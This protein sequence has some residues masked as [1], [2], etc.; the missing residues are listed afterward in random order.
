MSGTRWCSPDSEGEARCTSSPVWGEHHLLRAAAASCSPSGP[1]SAID[2]DNTWKS[3]EVSLLSVGEAVLV[4]QR[5]ARRRRKVRVCR[6]REREG[7]ALRKGHDKREEG[8]HLRH[9]GLVREP[10]GPRKLGN[11]IHMKLLPES[12][13]RHRHR[14][15]E[16]WGICSA[17]RVSRRDGVCRLEPMTSSKRTFSVYGV[18]QGFRGLVR[19]PSPSCSFT[20]ISFPVDTHTD[21]RTSTA[22]WVLMHSCSTSTPA[23]S[24]TTSD[25]LLPTPRPRQPPLHAPSSRSPCLSPGCAVRY[26]S[27]S[28]RSSRAPGAPRALP[29]APRRGSQPAR[30][31]LRV[32]QHVR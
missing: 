23:S 12:H 24:L 2:I 25:T 30:A 32:H 17:R 8:V 13:H 9:L 18:G 22:R 29:A 21:A 10:G 1:H 6:N 19:I 3:R 28:I 7:L 14:H 27:A 11:I 16:L 31:P 4:R 5:H 20:L 26:S 15:R